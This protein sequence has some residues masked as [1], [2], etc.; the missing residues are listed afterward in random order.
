M[1]QSPTAHA[2]CASSTLS[3]KLSA[4]RSDESG[5]VERLS[6]IEADI[7]LYQ[8]R[9]DDLASLQSDGYSESVRTRKRF[10]LEQKICALEA[11]RTT[12]IA[13]RA[14]RRR[15]IDEMAQRKEA[16]DAAL[17]VLRARAAGLRET[18]SA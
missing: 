18:Q 11:L 1:S 5:C 9:L 16:I 10:I 12:M 3:K 2:A 13:D 4:A 15:D 8:A 14:R 6:S 17:A 7:A